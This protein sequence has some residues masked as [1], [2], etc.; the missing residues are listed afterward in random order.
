MRYN[1]VPKIAEYAHSLGF[2]KVQSHDRIHHLHHPSGHHLIV[3]WEGW[4]H[5][6]PSGRVTSGKT[7]RS[8]RTELEKYPKE[9]FRLSMAK[10]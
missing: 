6:D 5:R 3:D 2:D 10:A 1:P 4:R 8:L 7:W 9:T